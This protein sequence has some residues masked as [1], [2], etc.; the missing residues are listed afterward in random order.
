[1]PDEQEVRWWRTSPGVMGIGAAVIL[2]VLLALYT[3]GLFRSRKLMAT[4]YFAN[5]GGLKPGAEVNLDGIAIG[6]VKSVTL[7]TSPELVKTPVKVVMKLNAK[8]QAGLHTDSTATITSLGA[9]G[10]SAIDINSREAAGPPLRDGDTLKAIAN[11]SV[12][13]AKAFQTTINNMNAMVGR[14]NTVVDE[15]ETGKGSLGQFI[16]NPGLTNE[17]A[18]TVGKVK[19]VT[20]KLNGTTNTVGKFIHDPSVSKKL[21]RISTNVQGVSASVAKLTG[22]PLQGNLAETQT[23]VNS[24]TADLNAGKGGLGML[25]TDSSVKKDLSGATAQANTLIAGIGAGKG[26]AGKFAAAGPVSVDMTKLQ[27]EA[28]ALATMIR[29]NPTKYLTIQVRIF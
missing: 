14:F 4:S 21:A 7:T 29:Q 25:M 8:Y 5:A 9:L 16:T 23:H 27:A 11:P 19:D 17:A 26:S 3:S 28:S 24:L 12:L 15:M 1:M 2:T 13:D 6:T 22:G 20:T 10:D 18:G